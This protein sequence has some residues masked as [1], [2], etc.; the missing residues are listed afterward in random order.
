MSYFLTLA[1]A[2]QMKTI[3]YQLSSQKCLEEGWTVRAPSPMLEDE[4]D[5]VFVPEPL[6]P[7]MIA[8]GKVGCKLFRN[9]DICLNL[10]HVGKVGCSVMVIFLS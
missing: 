2:R 8:E 7:L 10:F 5:D 9:V 6:N 1:V 3:N 4:G